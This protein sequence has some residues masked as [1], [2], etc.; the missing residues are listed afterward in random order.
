LPLFLLNIIH[1][2]SL[3]PHFCHILPSCLLFIAESGK[4]HPV[5]ELLHNHKWLKRIS[6]KVS[7]SCETV[8]CILSS[9]LCP[10]IFREIWRHCYGAP[11]LCPI[12]ATSSSSYV[13]RLQYPE[14]IHCGIVPIEK[15][16][17]LV[18]LE[19]RK[20]PNTVVLSKFKRSKLKVTRKFVKTPRGLHDRGGG[21]LIFSRNFCSQPQQ[22]N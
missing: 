15:L 16:K 2:I 20:P 1:F 7:S 18:A 22:P 4:Y 9:I 10:S 17:T 13:F 5:V 11:L 21:K 3:T 19:R 14:V 6:T 12:N 8:Q